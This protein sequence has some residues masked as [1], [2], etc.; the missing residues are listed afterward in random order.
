MMNFNVSPDPGNHPF[1]PAPLRSEKSLSKNEESA[2]QENLKQEVSQDPQEGGVPSTKQNENDLQAALR[3]YEIQ[4]AE[5]LNLKGAQLDDKIKAL[6]SGSPEKGAALLS[7]INRKFGGNTEIAKTLVLLMNIELADPVRKEKFDDL[8]KAIKEPNPRAMDDFFKAYWDGDRRKP[9]KQTLPRDTMSK[10]VV[11]RLDRNFDPSNSKHAAINTAFAYNPTIELKFLLNELATNENE[12]AFHLIVEKINND[13]PSNYIDFLRDVQSDPQIM[14]RLGEKATAQLNAMIHSAAGGTPAQPEAQ[15]FLKADI[16]KVCFHRVLDRAFVDSPNKD[17]TIL[18]KMFKTTRQTIL[19]MLK[20]IKIN[21]RNEESKID[22]HS[23]IIMQE[24]K[25]GELVGMSFSSAMH[26]M[27]NE[28]FYIKNDSHYN[29]KYTESEKNQIESLAQQLKDCESLALS[30]KS[31]PNN[32]G[33]AE[34]MQRVNEKIANLSPGQSMILPGG[35]VDLSKGKGHSMLYQISRNPNGTYSFK[36]LN[37]GN[38][39]QHHQKIMDK[40]ETAIVY[41]Q[42]SLKRLTGNDML[43]NLLKIHAGHEDALAAASPGTSPVHLIYD[44]A[45]NNLGAYRVYSASP[46]LAHK[47]QLNGTCS[48]QVIQT[49]LHNSMPNPLYHRF[50]ADMTSHTIEMFENVATDSPLDKAMLIKMKQKEA[51]RTKK[52]DRIS[53]RAVSSA[54]RAAKKMG[55]S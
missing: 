52:A 28:L 37:T 17:K 22:E 19:S 5:I 42:L 21:S 15:N 11:A 31:T 26:D 2:D 46:H 43:Q 20:F 45:M 54:R 12:W 24:A 29:L 27:K 4:E 18:K 10:L 14:H 41:D 23:K 49:W 47:E 51:Y 13:Q 55:R 3:Q 1:T 38:G 9:S 34:L 35:Y 44:A 33:F 36:I 50:K 30:A 48:Q 32:S 39:L 40:Y 53:K 25:S 7:Q 6:F 16:K 8:L